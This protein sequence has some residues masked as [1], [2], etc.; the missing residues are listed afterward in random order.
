MKNL[1]YPAVFHKDNEDG[2]YIVSFPDLKGCVTY[3]YTLEEAFN[4]AGD[5]LFA[6]L[7][8][9]EDVPAP[10][11]INAVACEEGDIALLVKAAV[12]DELDEVQRKRV[13]REIET[14]LKEKGYT[15][16]QVAQI[17]GVDRSYIT[18][19]AKGDSTPA[20]DMAKRI[21]LL[22]GIDWHVFF[23]DNAAI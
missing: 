5:A 17:L 9:F 22:L 2:T 12:F 11:D 21:G 4:M 3:G 1:I 15:K 19:I 6:W 14:G 10:S 8:A 18:K 20:P 13:S 7:D 23:A 16:N